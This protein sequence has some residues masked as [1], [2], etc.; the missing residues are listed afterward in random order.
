LLFFCYRM[1]VCWKLIFIHQRLCI[2][3]II[4]II[5][6]IIYVCVYLSIHPSIHLSIRWS[7]KGVHV[8]RPARGGH[9]H[10]VEVVQIDQQLFE[11]WHVFLKERWQAVDQEGMEWKRVSSV[12]SL[13][14]DQNL[15]SEFTSRNSEIV[16][17]GHLKYL[18]FFF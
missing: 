13:L 7:F 16:R 10:V 14:F 12:N 9:G 15:A 11:T 5:Y 8:A 6:Y 1:V 3:I 18:S 2:I 4:I 17:G